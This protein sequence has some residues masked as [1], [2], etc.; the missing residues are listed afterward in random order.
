MRATIFML[1]TTFVAILITNMAF[2][3]NMYE[4]ANDFF[5]LTFMDRHPLSC[6]AY[7]TLAW[8]ALTYFYAHANKHIDDKL[9]RVSLIVAFSLYLTFSCVFFFYY[10]ANYN[11]S[12]LTYT[13]FNSIFVTLGN[14]L[15]YLFINIGLLVCFLIDYKLVT[16]NRTAKATSTPKADKSHK[17][18]LFIVLIV[19]L[20]LL[21]LNEM[22][23]FVTSSIL[24]TTYHIFPFSIGFEYSVIQAGNGLAVVFSMLLISSVAI[25]CLGIFIRSVITDFLLIIPVTVISGSLVSNIIYYMLQGDDLRFSPLYIFQLNFSDYINIYNYKI[26]VLIGF[27]IGFVFAMICLRKKLY[28]SNRNVLGAEKK[29]SGNLGSA[30]LADVKYLNNENLIISQKSKRQQEGHLLGS[31]SNNYVAL[32]DMDRFRS[33]LVVAPS[34]SGKGVAVAVNRILDAKENMFILDIKSELFQTTYQESIRKGK[35]PCAIDPYNVL[36]KYGDFNKYRIV[37]YDPMNP[38]GIDFSDSNMKDYY[39][40]ALA[41][42]LM[43]ESQFE[44]DHFRDT[45]MS[46]LSAILYGYL[47]T[48]KTLVEIHDIYAPLDKEGT[49]EALESL[50]K[51]NSNTKKSRRFMSAMGLLKKVSD[52]EAGSMLSTLYRSFDY[53]VATVWSDFFG[54]SQLNMND[55]IT[56]NSDFYF[57][58]PTSMV[59]RYPKIIRLMLRMFMVHFELADQRKLANRKC[60]V[61]LDEVAQLTATSEIQQLLEI[62]GEKG[63]CLSLFFQNISQIDQFKKADLIKGMD[64]IHIFSA[65]DLKTIEWVNKMG[66]RRTI[67]DISKSENKSKNRSQKDLSGSVGNSS[68]TGEREAQA[69]LFHM[70]EIRELPHDKQFIFIKGLRPFIADKVYYYKDARYAG[71]FGINYVEFKDQIKLTKDEIEAPTVSPVNARIKSLAAIV[72]DRSGEIKS[73]AKP[74]HRSSFIIDNGYSK[75]RAENELAGVENQSL[76][77]NNNRP[78]NNKSKDNI[79]KDMSNKNTIITKT[80]TESGKKQ[81]Q[82]N[83]I[84]TKKN[85]SKKYTIEEAV[86]VYKKGLNDGLSKKEIIEKYKISGYM[87]RKVY[88]SVKAEQN[89]KDKA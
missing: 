42:S 13:Y 69:D 26:S 6:F 80:N 1:I 11:I 86:E 8:F 49:I 12:F 62:Y 34:R 17:S 87:Y 23:A 19:I 14:N 15:A 72:A 76:S 4:T 82:A 54:K 30:K 66:G 75:E 78:K 20:S 84:S 28:T 41:E 21:V 2:F 3:Y 58:M 56:E 73:D 53:V 59:K 70:N 27:V 45:A 24:D 68:G 48:G 40:E 79:H 16:R 83:D 9:C 85:P 5:N 65:N 36:G 64:I 22:I 7:G 10:L 67:I 32:P 60:H 44:N 61:M 29:T 52:K 37:N 81:N 46:I 63:V 57:I 74:L 33:T 47:N 51:L 25:F 35:T 55:C 43:V 39:I 77:N 88:Q 71:R 50:G 89:N 18:W 31:L 38:I